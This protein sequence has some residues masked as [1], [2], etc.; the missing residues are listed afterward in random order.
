MFGV[1]PAWSLSP[2]LLTFTNCMKM[3]IAVI[4]GV[5][6]MSTGVFVKGINAVKYSRWMVLIFEVIGGLIIL[7]GLFGWMDVLIVIKW[8]F[9]M[10]PYDDNAPTADATQDAKFN[11]SYYRIAVA[12]S[13]ITVMINNF[14]VGGVQDVV[15]SD[16]ET[17]AV[18]EPYDF[19]YIEGQSAIS[20]ALVLAV[21][22]CVPLMLCCK[23]CKIWCFPE[24][25]EDHHDEF[26]NIQAA[27]PANELVNNMEDDAKADIKAYEQLLNSESDKHKPHDLSEVF[28]HQLIETIEFVLGTISNTASYL[29]LWALSLAHS[30]LAGVFLEYG[31][32]FAW[33][34]DNLAVLI[35]MN[36]LFWFPF[37]VVSFGVL[38]LMDFLECFLH[39]LRLHWVEFQ[40]K[41]F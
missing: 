27:E 4:I 31:L 19:L 28:I 20:E 30:Q 16:P 15:Y 6:H 14:L 38:L 1:D 25:H 3:K 37:M 32:Q 22:F 33:K 36:F 17:G 39:T 34:A 40:N 11:N 10:D 7:W 23:P 18:D 24:K 41:F 8:L 5:I 26:Q 9:V 35:I 2:Q 12:P 29:R 13:I 21:L